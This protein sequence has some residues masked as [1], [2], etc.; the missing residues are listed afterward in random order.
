[1]VQRIR[2]SI[3]ITIISKELTKF[4]LK[5]TYRA[6]FT[7]IIDNFHSSN[8]DALR[9]PNGDFRLIVACSQVQSSLASTP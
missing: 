7:E 6:A 9:F 2:L 1:M 5:Y 3:V 4:S 8:T